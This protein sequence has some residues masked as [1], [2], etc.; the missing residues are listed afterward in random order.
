MGIPS[1]RD[2][3][4]PHVGQIGLPPEPNV[5]TFLILSGFRVEGFR[6]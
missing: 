4:M 3:L 1:H 6:V 2:C 5:K